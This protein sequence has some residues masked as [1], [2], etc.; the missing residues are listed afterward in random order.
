VNR[1]LVLPVVC[2]QYRKSHYFCNCM[3][4]AHKFSNIKTLA[5]ITAL[6]TLSLSPC[7]ATERFERS[8]YKIP[9]QS[10]WRFK[11]HN[12]L[13]ATFTGTVTFQ[14]SVAIYPYSQNRSH[15]FLVLNHAQAKQFPVEKHTKPEHHTRNIELVYSEK[16]AE[17][18]LKQSGHIPV[19][20]KFNI[21]G[22]AEVTI[23]DFNIGADCQIPGYMS[24]QYRI[25]RFS[26]AHEAAQTEHISC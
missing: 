7:L 21:I 25:I 8:D 20:G 26:P 22:V 15:I 2:R 13:Y 14:A 24:F 9:D 12:G 16:L 18:L 23:A 5:T 6:L 19:P 10:P 17:K 11:E 1:Y 3:Q 4:P